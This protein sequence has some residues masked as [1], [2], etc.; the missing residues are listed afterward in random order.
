MYMKLIP[1]LYFKQCHKN[2]T[3]N[4][5]D[6]KG[7]QDTFICISFAL[8]HYPT[9]KTDITLQSNLQSNIQTKTGRQRVLL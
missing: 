2:I 8:W 3:I 6:V 5:G 1:T 9:D 4:C 7:L